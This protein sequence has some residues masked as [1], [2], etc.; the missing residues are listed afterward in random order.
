MKDAAQIYR[1]YRYAMRQLCS[2]DVEPECDRDSED[3]QH[4]LK[5]CHGPWELYRDLTGKCLPFD[6]DYNNGKIAA[7]E[8]RYSSLGHSWF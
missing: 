2:I 7:Y 6:D 1:D 3:R 8:Y 4:W 5:R